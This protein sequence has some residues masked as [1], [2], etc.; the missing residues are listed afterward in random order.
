MKY[1]PF[2]KSSCSVPQ[3]AVGCMR[4]TEL[5]VPQAAKYLNS[6]IESE[7]IFFDHA[8]IYGRGECELL[9]SKALPLNE[10]QREKVFI[11]SKCGIVPGV[12][13]NFSKKHIIESV[14]GS[15]R[16]LNTN[17]LDALLLHRPD[18][19]MDPQ[20]V[21]DA[22]NTLYESGK[23]KFFGVSNQNPM[24]IKL[25]QKYL[26]QPIQTNQL[27]F[28]IAHAEMISNGINVNTLNN[29]A[30]S[31]DGSI[32]DF[33]RLEDITIQAWSPFQ[34]GFFE[35]VFLNNEKFP[36]LNKVL[37]RIAG[38]NG[39]TS[40]AVATAWIMRHPAKMQVIAGTMKLERLKEITQACSF[41]LSRE[42]WYE[43]YKSAGNT[44]P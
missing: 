37:T 18:T 11:Q 7:L 6:A 40:T 25:L 4:L 44:L 2:G 12:S 31:R 27:Q 43:I 30:I 14:E 20:E 16:R 34:Y 19:L 28:G 41:D 17:Y 1:I 26:T 32:L 23:V 13:Y 22:F 42:E 15:L 10:D 33:C 3:I 5:S 36:E 29:S 8:D 38:E 21:A 39:V 35:G 9:F 24:Q